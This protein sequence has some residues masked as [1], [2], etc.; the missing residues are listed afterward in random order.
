[1]HYRCAG[2][3]AH[4]KRYYT[5]RGISV[6]PRWGSFENFLADMGPMPTPGLT[7][8]R[9][10]NDRGYGPTNC[11]WSTWHEQFRNKS[12]NRWIEI[13]GVRKTLSDWASDLKIPQS[14]VRNR[15]N[16]GV[17]PKLALGLL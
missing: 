6:D 16:R 10:D 4:H 3:D 14:T 17:P 1:M 13:D 8:E 11:K 2:T 7:L 12:N 15:L 5:D 9:K